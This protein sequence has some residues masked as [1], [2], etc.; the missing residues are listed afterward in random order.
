MIDEFTTDLRREA[1]RAKTDLHAFAGWGEGEMAILGSNRRA[2][3]GYRRRFVGDS[4]LIEIVS[5]RVGDP[6][7]VLLR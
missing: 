4:G 5:C 1:V 7:A 3:I 2:V 6:L